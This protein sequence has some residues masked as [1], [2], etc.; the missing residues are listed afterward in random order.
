VG[1]D[2]GHANV[3]GQVRERHASRH[4]RPLTNAEPV[5]GAL[6]TGGVGHRS[7]EEQ[8]DPPVARRRATDR[9]GDG[10]DPFL[11]S[12]EANEPTTTSSSRKPRRPRRSRTAR[13][14]A[15]TAGAGIGVRITT[16]DGTS[17][18]IASAMKSLCTATAREASTGIRKSG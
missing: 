8:P 7:R 11:R 15:T 14:S 2:V 6:Q 1:H 12:E 10:L 5:E 18:R 13:G 17:A 9:A 16:A 4:D 3:R